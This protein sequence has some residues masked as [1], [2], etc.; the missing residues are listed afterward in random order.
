MRYMKWNGPAAAVLLIISCFSP[1]VFIESRNI[2]VSG[3]DTTGTNF[4]KPGYFHFLMVG[5]FLLFSFIQKVGFKRG[6][7]LNNGPQPRLGHPE[8]FYH[9]CLPGRRLPNKKNRYLPDAAGSHT[10]DGIGFVSGY[11][12][13]G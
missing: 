1:W 10:H 8:L 12:I 3:I 5:F 13:A 9:F 7:S 6:Q 11:E 4:G 2:T